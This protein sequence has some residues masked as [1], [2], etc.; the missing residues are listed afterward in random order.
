MI[1]AKN[2]IA[3]N[4]SSTSHQKLVRYFLIDL[5]YFKTTN[6][7]RSGEQRNRALRKNNE[8]LYS[9]ET[10]E[11]SKLYLPKQSE[12]GQNKNK[13]CLNR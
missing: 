4:H 6:N 9:V 2:Q 1:Q 3:K 8:N 10:T 7:G 13:F 11:L 12:F 5:S